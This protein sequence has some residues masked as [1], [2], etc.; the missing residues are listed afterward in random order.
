MDHKV[1]AHRILLG[2][3]CVVLAAMSLPVTAAFLDTILDT[4]M[5][6]AVSAVGA[7]AVGAGAGALLPKA[8]GSRASAAQGAQLGGILGL[9]A[10]IVGDIA[11][12]FLL[13]G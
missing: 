11:W 5:L 1:L 4:L 2:L 7:A 13:T 9:A 12:Y 6:L 8:A 3:V 10:S